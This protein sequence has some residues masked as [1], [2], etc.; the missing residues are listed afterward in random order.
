[1]SD[2]YV[3]LPSK[4]KVISEKENVGVYEIEGFHPGFGHTIGNSLRRII[5][6]SLP[7]ASVTSVKIDGVSHEFSTMDGIKEDTIN[8]LLNIKKLRFRMEGEEPAT[9]KIKVKGAKKVTS[10]DIELPGQLELFDK[11]LFLAEI[12]DKNTSLDIEMTIEKGLGY[13]PKDVLHKEKV[14][15]GVIGLDATFTPIRRVNYEVEN[16]RVGDRTDFNR[17]RIYIETDGVVTPREALEKSIETM[18]NQLRAIVGFKEE[19]ILPLNNVEADEEVVEESSSEEETDASKIKIEDLGLSARTTNALIGASV[20][21]VGGLV[22]KSGDDILALE[23]LGAKAVSEIGDA[24]KK[25]GLN[26]KE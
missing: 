6:S 20:K 1:M 26:L 8:L 13:V 16:M 18:I 2:H 11:D 12:T 7:G 19:E 24:L 9:A 22:R 17:L 21:T 4:P 3:V 14:G 5:L 23:G 15:V 25:H 10:G